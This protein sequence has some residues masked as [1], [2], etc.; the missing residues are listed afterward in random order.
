[1]FWS[2]PVFNYTN[3]V[4]LNMSG[5]KPLTVLQQTQNQNPIRL[6]L[7][8]ETSLLILLEAR[9]RI[10]K[11]ENPIHEHLYFECLFPIPHACFH[12]FCYWNQYQKPT[13][14]KGYF[15]SRGVT[16][17]DGFRDKNQVWRPHVRTWG[18]SEG[19]VLLCIE[20][21]IVTLLGFFGARVIAPPLVTS[22]LQQLKLWEGFNNTHWQVPFFLLFMI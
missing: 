4:C 22:L 5:I 18:L 8:K 14:L 3:M 21:I 11:I 12:N 13:R 19:N 1:M 10:E 7:Y 9:L 6:R 17:K 16:R 2:V 20:K 15:V